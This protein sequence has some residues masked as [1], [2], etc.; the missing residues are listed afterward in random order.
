MHEGVR[1]FCPCH[2]HYWQ[3]T[4]D[5]STLQRQSKHLDGNGRRQA[6]SLEEVP[7]L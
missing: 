7:A 1:T 2:R 3:V 6:A 4:E 5:I